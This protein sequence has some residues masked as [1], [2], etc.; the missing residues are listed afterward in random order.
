M[1][2]QFTSAVML[3]A[4]RWYQMFPISCRDL[5]PIVTMT[6]RGNRY[7]VRWTRPGRLTHASLRGSLTCFNGEVD[8]LG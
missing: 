1:G 6:R 2:R 5:E 4:V 7:A 8:W 3:W